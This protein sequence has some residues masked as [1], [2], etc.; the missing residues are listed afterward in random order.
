MNLYAAFQTDPNLEK[1]G[2]LI[3]YGDFKFLIARAGGENKRFT[4]ML[5]QKMRPHARAAAAGTLSDEVSTRVVRECFCR[6]VLLDWE[7]VTDAEGNPLP[8][9]VEAAEKVLTDLPDLFE[10]LLDQA[11]KVSNFLAQTREESSGN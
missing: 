6:T 5:Q 9:S 2:V 1:N 4:K 8:F 11:K 7:G 3:D 10:D